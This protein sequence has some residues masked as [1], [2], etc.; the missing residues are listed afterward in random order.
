MILTAYY[1]KENDVLTI[2]KVKKNI[3]STTT[4]DNITK[5]YN[6]E[7]LIG[8]N[9][10]NPGEYQSGLVDLKDINQ[11]LLSLFGNEEFEMPFKIGF[12]KTCEKHP[13]SEKL[14]IC[15]VDL[16]NKEVQIVCGAKNCEAN[17][18]GVV[19][20]VGAVMPSGMSIV[21]SKVIDVPSDGMLC[22]LKELGIEDDQASGIKLFEKEE[23][24]I[25]E[26][27]IKE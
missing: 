20:Q 11:E 21:S 25:G 17:K 24:K 1:N 12:I 8:L 3:T 2:T 22:S 16:G 26:T 9:I 13:K 7:E 5:I 19:A 15:E 23:K 14:Q 10:F 6:D 4:E 18:L 27:F